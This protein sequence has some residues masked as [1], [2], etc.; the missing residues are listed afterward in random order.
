MNYVI[1]TQHKSISWRWVTLMAIFGL[2]HTI[3][4][5]V[6]INLVFTIKKFINNPAVINAITSM[7]VAFNLIFAATVLYISDRIWTRYGRRKIFMIPAYAMI[8][9][10]FMLLPLATNVWT[11]LAAAVL[12]YIFIDVAATFMTLKMEVVPPHQRGRWSGMNA[13]ITQI[14]VIVFFVLVG[15]RFDDVITIGGFRLTGEMFSYWMG[16][17]AMLIGLLFLCFFVKEVEPEEERPTFKGGFLGVYKTVFANKQLFPVY[18]L[19]FCW[20]MIQQGLGAVDPLLFTEQWGYVKQDIGTNILAGGLLNLIVMPIMGYLADKVDRI[21]LITIGMVGA[22][23]GKIG[24][25]IWVQ[26][27][28]ADN[29]PEIF[30]I[31]VFGYVASFFGSFISIA[32]WPL[33]YDYIPRDKMGTAQTGL[34]VIRTLSR[35]ILM[36]GVGVFITAYSWLFLPEG[37]YDYFSGYLF[38]IVTDIIGVAIVLN[39]IYQTKKG[40]LEKVGQTSFHPVEEQKGEA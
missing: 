21:K 14:L 40:K 23:L 9:I 36:N 26:F 32:F 38:L 7:D 18:L 35:F 19:M 39:F 22:M 28:L 30:H 31:I 27:I 29:R 3:A 17:F 10:A 34:M 13:W 24:Y 8:A 20:L 2:P 12:W 1:E 16:S 4:F 25:Y 5:F 33:A 15:P 6:T 11:M 37:Q